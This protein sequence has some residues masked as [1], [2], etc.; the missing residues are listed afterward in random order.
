MYLEKEAVDF[1]RKYEIQ[2]PA[3]GKSHGNNPSRISGRNL[4]F[5][6]YKQ[7]VPGDDIRG[8]DW[9]VYGRTEK[10]FLKN[11][12]SDISSKV[13]FVLDS[14]ES[15]N[16]GGKFEYM[17][18][19]AAI[20]FYLLN[21]QKNDVRFSTI[22]E[23]YKDL[24]LTGRSTLETVLDSITVSGKT[25][26]SAIETNGSETVFFFSDLWF[27]EEKFRSIASKRIHVIHICAPEELELALHG[28]VELKDSEAGTYLTLVPSEVRGKYIERMNERLELFRRIARDHE[29]A[30]RLFRTD[31]RYYVELKH[32]LEEMKGQRMRN[33]H[34]V[35]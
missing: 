18:S 30:Y 11:Y 27:S 31:N 26:P 2:L 21:A 23:D 10:L 4:E 17:K 35:S 6:K 15:M 22:S 16:F 12:G 20:F 1:F 7:Y 24:G 32:Y 33:K 34:V 5:E 25:N 3:R 14:S 13:R 9:K 28:S 29:I 19:T 8:I